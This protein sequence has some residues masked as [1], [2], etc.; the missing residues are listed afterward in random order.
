MDGWREREL[1]A[2]EVAMGEFGEVTMGRAPLDEKSLDIL[3]ENSTI[4]WK[5]HITRRRDA[6][7]SSKHAV[8]LT[9]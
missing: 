1:E 6:G 4:V 7:C 2:I 3:L 8:L 5:L 9:T